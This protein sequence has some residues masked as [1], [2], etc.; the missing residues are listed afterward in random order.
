MIDRQTDS[1]FHKKVIIMERFEKKKMALPAILYA[2]VPCP[3][4][5]KNKNEVGSFHTTCVKTAMLHAT[6]CLGTISS[7]FLFLFGPALDSIL[8]LVHA[9]LSNVQSEKDPAYISKWCAPVLKR[10]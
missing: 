9:N 4:A 8:P 5:C 10:R 7:L 6:S 1:I 3:L 2:N